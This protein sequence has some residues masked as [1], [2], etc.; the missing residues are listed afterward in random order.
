[1]ISHARRREQNKNVENVLVKAKEAIELAQK[2]S[3]FEELAKVQEEQVI[4]LLK[5]FNSKSIAI[6][7][8]ILNLIRTE[9]KPV[10]DTAE[11]EKN[12]TNAEQVGDA[13]A[14]MSKALI[15]IHKNT[16]NVSGSVRQYKDDS[17]SPDGTFNL[18]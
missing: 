5:E 4:A 16:V 8:V 3:Y 9:S 6:D 2:Q 15:E 7:D 12:M 10:L 17:N 11:Y 18:S 14:L 1:M 13:V